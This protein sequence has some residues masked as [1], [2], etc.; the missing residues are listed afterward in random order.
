MKIFEHDKVCAGQIYCS[1][2][3]PFDSVE[4]KLIVVSTRACPVCCK[5]VECRIVPTDF[6]G[7]SVHDPKVLVRYKYLYEHGRMSS[8][9]T[10]CG[11]YFSKPFVELIE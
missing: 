7:I 8:Q 1:L 11:K 5:G 2:H 9:Y 6:R 10:R 4:N 3:S